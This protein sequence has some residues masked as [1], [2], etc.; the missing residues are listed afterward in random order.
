MP[1]VGCCGSGVPASS[2]GANGALAPIG[3][4]TRTRTIMSPGG[5][6][7]PAGGAAPGRRSSALSA[8]PGGTRTGTEVGPLVPVG[9]R[10]TVL[11]VPA[12]AS[13]PSISITG[14]PGAAKPSYITRQV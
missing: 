13:Q 1:D 7:G 11:V 8:T 12:E 3:L 4:R 2:G 10:W 9:G 14:S 5:R 6:P